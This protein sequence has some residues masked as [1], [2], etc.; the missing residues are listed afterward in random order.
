MSGH[1]AEVTRCEWSGSAMAATLENLPC[2]RHFWN[3]VDQQ[4]EPWKSFFYTFMYVLKCFFPLQNKRLLTSIM[5]KNHLWKV[6]ASVCISKLWA[7]WQ[8]LL[9]VIYI[10]TLLF[11][12]ISVQT[13][14][15]LFTYLQHT[16]RELKLLHKKPLLSHRNKLT[17]TLKAMDSS[18]M[19]QKVL[20]QQKYQKH[21]WMCK[22]A[23]LDIF[24]CLLI[25]DS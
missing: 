8:P 21:S 11:T 5:M 4:R 20:C 13:E 14:M 10:T 7:T 1:I 18:C 6:N 22:L 17:F 19:F 23:C 12:S 3:P 16:Y 24:R 15:Y 9:A 2:S 25:L